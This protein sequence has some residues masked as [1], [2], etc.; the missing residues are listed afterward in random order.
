MVGYESKEKPIDN[1]NA[2]E[3]LGI[4]PVRKWEK[5][6]VQTIDVLVRIEKE[7]SEAGVDIE[8][9]LKKNGFRA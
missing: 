7:W 1:S 5:T 6:V 2:V 3:R 9:V 4:P 8:S